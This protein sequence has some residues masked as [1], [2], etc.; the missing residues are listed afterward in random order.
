V[1]HN[2][3]L[4]EPQ[5]YKDYAVMTDRWRLVSRGVS[6]TV[7]LFDHAADPG[8]INDVADKHPEVVERLLGAYDTWWDDMTPSFDNISHHVVGS[9]YE[10][11]VLLTCHCWRTPCKEKSYNQ[12]HVREGIAINDAYW[13]IEVASDGRY[14]IELRRWPREADVAISGSVPVLSEPFCDPLPEGKA[15]AITQA[16]LA[17]QGIDKTIQ[18]GKADKGA[19][20]E[21]LLKK[22]KTRLQTWFTFDGDQTIGAYYV[23]VEKL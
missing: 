10:N 6:E 21:V 13:P 8:Q 15:Y 17:V 23:Y 22:G 1:V 14:R 4:V 20:F 12:K 3:Q 7:E 5:K 18:V 2:M 16:R 19:V 11:P 9:E